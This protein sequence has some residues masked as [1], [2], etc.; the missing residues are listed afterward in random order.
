MESEVIL[1]LSPVFSPE[2]LLPS[3]NS[4]R[5]SLCMEM[6][7]EYKKHYFFGSQLDLKVAKIV[8]YISWFCHILCIVFT[9][10]FFLTFPKSPVR[11]RAG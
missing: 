4:L 5:K 3:E 6:A 7:F 9:R 11:V 2:V 10:L 8:F 1:L